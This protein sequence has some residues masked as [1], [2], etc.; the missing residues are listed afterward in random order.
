MVSILTGQIFGGVFLYAIGLSG[1][2]FSIIYPTTITIVNDTYGRDSSYFIG[3]SAIATSIGIF[4]TNLIF[5]Y[6]N[7]LI[8]VQAT[9]NLIPVC[10][11]YKL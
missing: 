3:I 7:D 9:F 11:F 5:G 4:M 6:L 2:F 1:I 8:G 10:L